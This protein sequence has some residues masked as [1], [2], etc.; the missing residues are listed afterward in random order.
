MLQQRIEA[1]IARGTREL[2]LLRPG[3]ALPQLT[4]EVNV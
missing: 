4:G 3:E 2:G 1:G